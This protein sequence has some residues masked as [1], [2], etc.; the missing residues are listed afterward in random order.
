MFQIVR[1]QTP[2]QRIAALGAILMLA[3]LAFLT[4]APSTASA[5]PIITLR[6]VRLHEAV[7]ATSATLGCAAPERDAR[8]IDVWPIETPTIA[9]EEHSFGTATVKFDLSAAGAVSD[10]SI[11]DSAGNRYLD[12]AALEIV[13]ESRYAP[14]VRNCV[15]TAG[16]YLVFI[17]FDDPQR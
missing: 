1:L 7:V 6:L 16:T 17:E 11:A 10:S 14:E 5:A 3:G 2:F 12:L 4:L 9:S 13:R 8:I 15:N